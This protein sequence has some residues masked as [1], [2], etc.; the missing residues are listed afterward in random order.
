MY[1]RSFKVR[2]METCNTAIGV[3]FLNGS[4]CYGRDVVALE[5]GRRIAHRIV[6]AC[7]FAKSGHMDHISD[8]SDPPYEHI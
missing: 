7:C 1:N 3:G 4:T 2:S 6:P 8:R 5:I